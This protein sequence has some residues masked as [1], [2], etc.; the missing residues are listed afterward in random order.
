MVHERRFV[1]VNLVECIDMD[2]KA[3][4]DED[5]E[6]SDEKIAELRERLRNEE[7]DAKMKAGWHKFHGTKPEED[8]PKYSGGVVVRGTGAQIRGLTFRGVF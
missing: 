6:M 8:V 7:T 4:I 3:P 2:K 5:L 1:V